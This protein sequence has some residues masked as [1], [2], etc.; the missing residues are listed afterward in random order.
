MAHAYLKN[1]TEAG[2]VQFCSKVPFVNRKEAMR[3]KG[4]MPGTHSHPI[5]SAKNAGTLRPYLCPVCDLWHLSH[6]H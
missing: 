6:V 2:R 5:A 1:I 4:S 3:A